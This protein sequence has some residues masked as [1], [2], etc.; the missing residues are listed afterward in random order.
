MLGF[1][2]DCIS[3]PYLEHAIGVGNAE[4]RIG[5]VVALYGLPPGAGLRVQLGQQSGGG[6]GV[7]IRIEAL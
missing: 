6:L 1:G 3:A 5:G 7:A 4:I 2:R